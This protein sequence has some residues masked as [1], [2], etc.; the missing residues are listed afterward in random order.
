M[1]KKRK[2]K[3]KCTRCTENDCKIIITDYQTANTD[4]KTEPRATKLDLGCPFKKS[5]TKARWMRVY[6]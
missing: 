2:T 4:L 5:V 1:S 3:F 6:K